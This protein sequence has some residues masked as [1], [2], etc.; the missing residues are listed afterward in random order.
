MVFDS[1][2][3]R[4]AFFAKRNRGNPRTDTKPTIIGRLRKRFKPTPEEL[5]KQRGARIKKEAEALKEEKR[6]TRQLELELKVEA[7]REKVRVRE[8]EARARLKKIDI[9]RREKTL[10]GRVL[11][12]ERKIVARGIKAV[13]KGIATPKRRKRKVPEQTGFFGI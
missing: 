4:K 12:A 13:K 8:E 3:Q 5:A 10:A 2:K 11:K 7:E 1:D 6:T 9:A